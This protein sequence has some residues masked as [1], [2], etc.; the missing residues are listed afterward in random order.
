M[1]LLRICSIVLLFFATCVGALGQSASG[2]VLVDEHGNLPCDESL[3]RLDN[4]FQELQKIPNSSGF[5]SITNKPEDRRYTVFRQAM[6]KAYAIERGFDAMRLKIVRANSNQEMRLQL[7]L[8]PDGGVTPEVKDVDMSYALP[9]GGKAFMFSWEYSG[10]EQICPKIDDLKILAEFLR[11]NS[12]ARANIVVRMRFPRTAR[13]RQ[14]AIVSS[15]VNKFGVSRNRIR[16]FLVKPEP[17]QGGNEPII[18][19]WY[20]P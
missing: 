7:W 15:L 12:V 6:I 11:Q 13:R 5:I 16:T 2:A 17:R 20:L 19:Y 1:S 9:A 18:E 14:R 10:F 4:F 3:G 8:I